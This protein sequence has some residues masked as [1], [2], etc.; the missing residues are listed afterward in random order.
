MTDTYV[1]GLNLSH[2]IS[3]ALVK[4][5]Q[6]VC[7]I[8]EERLNRIKRFA[9]GVD[10]E[11]MTNKHVPKLSVQYCLE[12]AEISITDVDLIVVSTCVVVNFQSYNIRQLTKSE[13]LEQLPAGIDETR[14]HIVGHHLGHA[15]SAFFPSSFEEAAIVIADG[16]GNLLPAENE[17]AD[18]P[19]LFEERVTLYH[20]KGD[21][22]EVVRRFTDGT[23]SGGQLRN[24]KHCSLGDFYQSATLFTGFKS[25]DE[26][27]TMGL[28]PYGSNRYYE[29][30]LG[31]I[32]FDNESMSIDP[33]FQ[34][35]KWTNPT[36]AYDGRFGNI[37]KGTGDPGEIEKDV[38]AAVQYALEEA[39]VN[40][41]TQAQ[42]ATGSRNLCLAG[43]IALNSVANK[44]I[45][46]RTAFDNIFVQPASGDDGCAIGN[47]LLGWTT[48]L[49]KPRTW[50][51][52]NAYTGRSYSD[53]QI[54]SAVRKYRQ[55]CSPVKTDNVLK[56]A[57]KL[58]SERKIVGWFQGGSEFGPRA[59][60]HRSILSDTR[61][62]EMRDLLNDKVKHREGFRPFAPSILQE[63]CS[64][65]FDLDCP[66]PYMLLI[67]DVKKPDVIPAATHVDQTARVQTVNKEDNGIYYDLIKE[68]HALTGVPV[69]LN[70]SFN[71]AG[72]PIVETP[73][74]A[75]RCFLCTNIDYLVLEDTILR[76]H[77]ARC[78]V[79]KVWPQSMKRVVRKKLGRLASRFPFLS[80]LKKAVESAGDVKVPG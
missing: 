67:A 72:E 42:Q 54:D 16:G 22:I 6:L 4:N 14:V 23:S 40:I 77:P 27:K 21:G 62:A 63:H 53:T 12:A 3:C 58:L 48:I 1:L 49:E 57:S 25:G 28:A 7:G 44:K 20:G 37:R 61:Y 33:A 17:A 75:I 73:E 64:E 11:G 76:K 79:L 36:G 18:S 47:A 15:A 35:N 10:H 38:A 19:N 31:A 34:F 29:D 32:K 74:D 56:A 52:K 55:W 60:G 51:M 45:L 59:L 30:F 5:G 39:L 2:D 26:G 43:G 8:A 69:I 46:D 65:Y 9:G 68:Y 66:S 78:S 50:R 70:T 80:R 71:V 13:V 24:E 41:A